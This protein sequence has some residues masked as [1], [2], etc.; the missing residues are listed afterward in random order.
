MDDL[1]ENLF[2]KEEEKLL[3]QLK[4]NCKDGGTEIDP[5]ISAPIFH[6]LAILYLER[7]KICNT[8]SE[9]MIRLIRS[10]ALL[11]AALVRTTSDANDIKCSLK[12]L[13]QHLLETAEAEQKDA[14]LF[15]KANHIKLSVGEMRSYVDKQLVEISNAEVDLSQSKINETE[16]NKIKAIE[17]LQNKITDDYTEIMANLANYC[18]QI[19]GKAPCGFAIVGIGSLAKKEITPFSDFMHVLILDSEVDCNDKTISRYFRWYSAIFQIILINLG[20]TVISSLLNTASSKFGSWFSDDVTKRGISFDGKLPWPCDLLL[21]GKRLA[22]TEDETTELIESVP[23]MLKWLNS[24]ENRRLNYR[25]EKSVSTCYIYGDQSI[26]SK[27]ELC[28]NGSIS[29]ENES[30]TDDVLNQIKY[31]L[32]NLSIRSVLMRIFDQGKCNVHKDIYCSSTLFMSALGILNHISATSGFEMIRQLAEKTVISGYAKNKLMY[33]KAIAC[34]LRLRWYMINKRRKA[35]I[36]IKKASSIVGKTNAINYFQIAYALQCDISKRF[37]L[38]KKHFYSHP[39]LLNI[40]IYLS[41]EI[42]EKFEKCINFFE[43]NSEEQYLL[44]FDQVLKILTTNDIKSNPT[45]AANTNFDGDKTNDLSD[46]FFGIGLELLEMNKFTDAKEYL[47]KSL[48]IKKQISSDVATDKDMAITLY[49]LGQCLIKMNKFTEANFYLEKALQIRQQITS[50]L[51]TDSEIADTFHKIGRC[52]IEM[53]KLTDAKDYLE[54]ALKIERRISS[55]VDTEKHIAEILY[56]IGRCLVEMNKP[57]DAKNS[58]EKALKIKQQQPKDVIFDHDE[59]DILYEIGRCLNEMNKPDDA[60]D[61]FEKAVK[62]KQQLISPELITKND[63]ADNLHDIGQYL[64]AT[65]KF[66]DA[67][68]YFEKALKIKQEISSDVDADMN[69]AISLLTLGRCFME[70][71]EIMNAIKHLDKTLKIL[72]QISRDKNNRKNVLKVD[73]QLLSDDAVNDRLVAFTLCETAKCLIRINLLIKAKEYLERALEIQEQISNDVAAD[74][75]IALTLYQVGRCLYRMRKF[76]D[77]KDYMEKTLEI[78]KRISND[79]ANDPEIAFT[80]YEIGRCLYAMNKFTDA[81]DYLE[82]SLE[83]ER[84]ISSDIATDGNAVS[85]MFA[86]G[87]CLIKMD[88]LTDAKDYLEKSL[89]IVQRISSDIAT[90]QNVAVILHEIGRCLIYMN[91]L[92]HAKNHLER[93]LEIKQRISSDNATDR[94][95]AFTL[96][97]IGR[98]LIKMH[99]FVVAKNHLERA[100]EIYQR[101]SSDIATDR[102][103]AFALNETGR[104]LIK[105]GKLIDAMNYLERALEIYQRTSSDN[106]T[107]GNVA[108]TLLETGRCL[109]KMGKLIDAKDC[110]LRALEIDQQKSSDIGTD[111]NVAFTFFGIGQ[112]LMKMNKLVDAKNYMER[113]LEIKQKRSKDIATDMNVA[114]TMHEIGRCLMKMYKLTEAKVYLEKT[115]KIYQRTSNDV[116][117]ERNVAVIM[118]EINRCNLFAEVYTRS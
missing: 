77:A 46:N 10:A 51:A 115:L 110:M 107:D 23:D 35:E 22:I 97:E 65:D 73:Q 79:V 4:N 95:V 101:T 103:V 5:Q 27:S 1:E 118:R 20:E 63:M 31:D 76:T 3:E 44:E 8:V 116:A 2:T 14:D 68:G 18:E 74:Q 91:V 75:D 59:A 12:E 39:D 13:H 16:I 58:L 66:A 40:N 93:A 15:D 70:M 117:A 25:F 85:T 83:M 29:T 81:I 62:I 86:I 48:I 98:C 78:E 21:D 49:K 61:N 50:N 52:L 28:V 36:S 41:F 89:E 42:N 105:M 43:V 82:K 57:I 34:E 32:E 102:N 87:R 9:C 94:N 96:I 84:R 112:C 30:L 111:R 26:Y 64:Y 45:Q 80:L 53:N 109:M 71:D 69:V 72:Q 113:A 90:D 19:M 24:V 47:E 17:S 11:N 7:S 55:D 114:F 6:N 67:K 88:E 108:Y 106:A 60:K 100:L 92:T 54:E 104:C 38:K 37:G 99:E 33:A 56:E